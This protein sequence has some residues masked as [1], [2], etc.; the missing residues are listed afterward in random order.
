MYDFDLDNP[1]TWRNYK[2][3][4]LNPSIPAELLRIGGT[5]AYGWPRLK[6]TWGGDEEFWYQGDHVNPPG[7]YLKYHLC[8]TPPVLAA[9]EYSDPITGEKRQVSTDVALPHGPLVVPLY[10]QEEIGKPRWVI[11]IWRDVGDFEIFKEEGYYH[12]LTV[13]REPIKESTGMGPYREIDTDILE[14][15]KGM[16]HF[17]ENTTEAEREALRARDAEKE[18]ERKQKDQAAIWDGFGEEGIHEHTV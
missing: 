12:L 13:Q 4:Y 16:L 5:N 8:F 10:H 17:A 7:W 2:R 15:L 6:V 9:Y 11:E 18:K 3:P 1:H 14:T